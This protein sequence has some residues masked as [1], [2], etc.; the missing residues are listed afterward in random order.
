MLLS[1]DCEVIKLNVVFWLLLIVAIVFLWLTMSF[2]FK[3]IGKWLTKLIE[4][5]NE[6]MKD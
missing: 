1:M 2:L 5:A 4:E 3:P 6:N